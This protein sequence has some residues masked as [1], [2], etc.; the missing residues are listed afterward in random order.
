MRVLILILSLDREPWRSLE[1]AQRATWAKPQQDVDIL[2]LQGVTRGPVRL[3]F[4]LVRKVMERIGLRRWFDSM[5]GRIAVHFPVRTLGN[6]VRVGTFEYWIGTSVK[7]RAGLRHIVKGAEFDYLVRTNSST[8][9]HVPS[10]LA[11]LQA[12]PSEGY[13][14]GADQGEIHAQGTCIILSR[15][16]V[17]ALARDDEWN[18]ELVD[19]AAVGV[20]ARRAGMEFQKLRQFIV[21]GAEW[22]DSCE[23]GDF[24]KSF[25]FRIKTR[26]QRHEDAVTLQLLHEKT[27]VE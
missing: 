13:Y 8:Y 10:L 1:E 14:A 15:D 9:I 2:Y 11:H 12:A 23:F 26:G 18:Y 27:M 6:I 5:Y 21:Y 7:M 24:S 22:V 25:I 16:L 17:E 19:D 4:L 3:A 20:A